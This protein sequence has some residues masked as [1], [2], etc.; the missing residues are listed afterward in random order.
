MAIKKMV[1]EDAVVPETIQGE[2]VKVATIGGKDIRVPK[3]KSASVKDP[4]TATSADEGDASDVYRTREFVNSSVATNTANYISD[5]GQPFQSYAAL[6]AYSGQ[7]TN[8]DYAFVV[9]TDAAGNTTY[10]RYKWSAATSAWAAEYVL[11][12]SSFTASQWAAI[13][14]G[15]TGTAWA[16]ALDAIVAKADRSEIIG[17]L[18]M[19]PLPKFLHAISFDDTYPADAAWLYAQLGPSDLGRCSAVRRGGKLWRNYDWTFD[20]AAE[21]VVKMSGNSTRFASVGVASVGSRLTENDV[22]SAVNSLYYKCLPGMTLDGINEKGVVCE[23]NVDGGPKTGWHGDA[24]DDGIHILAAVRWVLDHGETAA[25]AAEWIADHIIQPQ[26]EMNFHFM[27]ADATATYIVENGAANLVPSSLL[28]GA[29]LTNYALYDS[30]HAG[31]GKER[32]ALLA[33]GADISAVN[34][35]NAYQP[36]NTWDSD[37][38]SAAQHAEA[39]RQWAEQGTDKESHRGKTTSSGKAWWQSVHTTEYDFAAKTMKVAVQEQDDWYVFAVDHANIDLSPIEAQ[40]AA[41]Q[42]GKRD[43]ADLSYNVEKSGEG[44]GYWTWDSGETARWSES[45]HLW[46][47]DSKDY[48]NDISI[49]NG[50]VFVDYF[51]DTGYLGTFDPEHK[52]V[53]S[54][55]IGDYGDVQVE[56]TYHPEAVED[57]LAKV[58][59]LPTAAEKAE[60]N[61]KQP[62]ITASGVLKGDGQ[63]GVSAATKSSTAQDPASADYRDPQDNT[64]HKTELGEWVASGVP[65]GITLIGQ[66]SIEESPSAEPSWTWWYR[67]VASGT[68]RAYI[69][70]PYDSNQNAT[71]LTFIEYDSLHPTF[72]AARSA[73]CTDGKP[74]TTFDIVSALVNGVKT[75]LGSVASGYSTFADWIASKFDT[76]KAV[77]AFAETSTY[78]VG[79]IV[80]YGG[81]A[82]KCTT[83]VTTAGEWTGYTNWTAASEAD[84]AS[85]LK[86]LK[87]NGFATDAF[88]ADLLGKSVANVKANTASL[89][90]AYSE[91]ET[92]AV[93]DAA[94]HDGKLYKCAVAITDA[95]AWTSAHWTETTVATLWNNADTTSYG[96]QN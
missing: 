42:D 24:E 12:N 71:E 32:Y 67:E 14:S 50:R 94:T 17:K 84:L 53:Y 54:G 43:Y 85:R 76:A 88:A 22:M 83:A 81:T 51:G 48:A 75:L 7:K 62:K 72:T 89:A 79:E 27:V 15:I 90:A 38:E 74:F 95:E 55:R 65:E 96:G 16:E 58:S 13:N 68:S 26:G 52:K 23:I 35:T 60:W 21:F 64:C 73:V 30:A 1:S 4:A 47:D 63:G 87:S 28:E 59:Q 36:G 46:R 40:I 77:P 57:S 70:Y 31:G 69:V 86:N 6:V 34:F 66:P 92:Y 5:N 10:T 41:L 2:T 61:S 19:K 49:E 8:N 37:F 18:P 82:Y 80:L 45:S 3:P 20:D 78:K 56:I 9:G 11:N 44:F 29:V 33:G 93:G 91:T 39:I 25:Q